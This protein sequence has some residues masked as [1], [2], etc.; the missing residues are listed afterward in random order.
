[1]KRLTRVAALAGLAAALCW[2]LVPLAY[3][4]SRPAGEFPLVLKLNGSPQFLGVIQSTGAS[5]TNHGTGVPFNNTGVA[6]K[7]KVLLLQ[8]DAAGYVLGVTTNNA[9]VTTA[10]GVKLAADERVIVT[11]LPTEGWLAW[12]S[13]T[14]TTNLR[15]WEI[16]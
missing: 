7:A 14:G 13:S 5:V 16:Q 4:Q 11:L 9:A 8:P 10:N 12:I 2:M 3:A 15:V 1:M 6:L